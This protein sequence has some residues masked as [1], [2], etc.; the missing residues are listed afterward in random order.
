MAVGG[1]PADGVA[2]ADCGVAVAAGGTR[3]GVDAAA[4]DAPAGGVGAAEGDCVGVGV[5]VELPVD[6]SLA[7]PLA[8]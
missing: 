4:G 5:G 7:V 8:L 1:A 6:G 2:E 3:P